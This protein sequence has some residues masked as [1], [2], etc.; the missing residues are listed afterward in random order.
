MSRME[1]I[2]SCIMRGDTSKAVFLKENDVPKDPDKRK[3]VILKI[4]GSPDKRQIDGLGGADPLTSKCAVI[5]P[6][7][8]DDA[9]VDYTF[10][11]IGIE[12]GSM[13][14]S[15]CG[16]ISAAVGPFAIDENLVKANEPVTEVKIYSTHTKRVIYAEVPTSEGKAEY[17][18]DFKIDGVPGTGP[19]RKL[20]LTGGMW[21]GLRRELCSQQVK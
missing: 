12:S 14:P 11:N 1:K 3:E 9:D 17:H 5:G 21:S 13:K 16:N 19:V 15:I 18:G 7:C 6:S 20:C 4:F 2:R 8:R 10:Y